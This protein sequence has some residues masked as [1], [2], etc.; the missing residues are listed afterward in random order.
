MATWEAFQPRER[1]VDGLVAADDKGRGTVGRTAGGG[2]GG[3]TLG[4]LG[5]RVPRWTRG[6]AAGL[7][8]GCYRLLLILLFGHYR[9]R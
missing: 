7:V 9:D 6:V 5:C 2:L 4:R 8:A 3:M 1:E